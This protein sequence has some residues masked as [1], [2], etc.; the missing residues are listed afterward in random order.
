MILVDSSAWVEFLRD[1]GS[2]VCER[3]ANLLDGEVATC[4]PVRMEVLAGARGDRH[5][6]DLRG[7]LGRGLLVQTVP[8]DYEEAASLYRACRREGETVRRLMNCLIAAH[9]IRSALPLLHADADF[10]ALAHH[11]RLEIDPL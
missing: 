9:A 4:H 6:S 3:V 7:L 8:G 2:T 1:T 5:L 10:E 11:S